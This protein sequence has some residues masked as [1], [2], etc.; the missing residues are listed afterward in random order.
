MRWTE[1]VE[2]R[3]IAGE[4]TL[5]GMGRSI[6][7]TVEAEV[8]GRNPG[9]RQ[10]EDRFTLRET[11]RSD[12]AALGQTDTSFGLLMAGGAMRAVGEDERKRERELREQEEKRRQEEE[13]QRQRFMA[14]SM[15]LR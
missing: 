4:E 9:L 5:A 12:G 1:I 7:V 10:E 2:P 13:L 15:S 3:G 6:A 14:M 11:W 8:V